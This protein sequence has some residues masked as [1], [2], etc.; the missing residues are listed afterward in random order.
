MSDLATL[1]MPNAMGLATTLSKSALIPVALRG[2]PGDVLVVLLTGQELG[3]GAMQALRSIHVVDGKPSLSADLMVGLCQRRRD[4]CEYFMCKETTPTRATYVTKRAGDPQPTE[5]SWTLEQA[6]Q[7]GLAGRGT[8][9]KYPDAMLRARCASALARLVYPDLLG[10][11][12]DS[13]SDE[14][15]HNK[16]PVDLPTVATPPTVD[17]YLN[18]RT[19]APIEPIEK[20]IEKPKTVTIQDSDPAAEGSAPDKEK[21]TWPIIPAGEAKGADATALNFDYL[22][23]LLKQT[24]N[25]RERYETPAKKRAAQDVLVVLR[26]EEKRRLALLEEATGGEA[27]PQVVAAPGKQA[28]TLQK[29]LVSTMQKSIEGFGN[30]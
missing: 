21:G 14:L 25:A 28:A 12:Y 10:G 1:D 16:E 11:V 2:K 9:S 27:P 22:M 18:P 6:K 20:P 7:A 26:Y 3:L 15:G 30:D 4:V 19:A 29:D 17:L 13:D 8:W 24:H 5:L 23:K